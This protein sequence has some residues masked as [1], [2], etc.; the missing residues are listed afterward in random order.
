MKYVNIYLNKNKIFFIKGV[1]VR[2]VLE[3]W[4]KFLGYFENVIKI[5]E[6]RDKFF[7]YGI[8]NLWIKI[9]F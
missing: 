8:R 4:V 7:L 9:Y 1:C 2:R 3:I 6:K 5:Y